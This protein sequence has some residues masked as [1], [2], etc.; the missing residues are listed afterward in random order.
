MQG[1]RLQAVG[2]VHDA[3]ELDGV[4]RRDLR[5]A[6]TAVRLVGQLDQRA[7]HVEV[8][9]VER[10]GRWARTAGSP[11]CRSRRGAARCGRSRRSPRAS[12]RAARCRG[13]RTAGPARGRTPC[14]SPPT[15]KSCAGLRPCSVKLDGASATCSS[16]KSGS[17]RTMVPSTSWPAASSRRRASGCRNS[18]PSSVTRRR[19]PPIDVL[20]GVL[21]QHLVARHAVDE[22]GPILALRRGV[23]Q[24]ASLTCRRVTAVGRAL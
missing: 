7:L 21:G 20:E 14:A 16:T 1:L 3:G 22:H 13:A 18:M 9:R 5:D 23:R 24:D 8:P 17:S 15:T 11:R 19:Q 10:A 6:G 12:P 4:A 2:A